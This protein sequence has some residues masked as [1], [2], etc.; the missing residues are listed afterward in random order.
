ML[1]IEFPAPATPTSVLAAGT[2]LSGGT[3]LPFLLFKHAPT[4]H[5]SWLITS[6]LNDAFL[7]IE[8]EYAIS[9]GLLSRVT[10]S[11]MG[12]IAAGGK[13]RVDSDGVLLKGVTEATMLSG[14]LFESGIA[15][16]TFIP[17]REGFWNSRVVLGG[18]AASPMLSLKADGEARIDGSLLQFLVAGVLPENAA[19]IRQPMYIVAKDR[20]T[21]AV[22]LAGRRM[23]G[24]VVKSSYAYDWTIEGLQSG[25]DTV[26]AAYESAK[27]YAGSQFGWI[28]I[29]M[30]EKA[31]STSAAAQAGFEQSKNFTAN[32]Y[33]STTQAISEIISETADAVQEGVGSG[34]RVITETTKSA[35]ESIQKGID[36]FA[37]PTIGGSPSAVERDESQAVCTMAAIRIS[38]CLRTGLCV[39][40]PE[41]QSQDTD[42]R[43]S[44]P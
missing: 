17:F 22:V 1:S 7:E 16:E 6:D 25:G 12:T 37:L 14:V 10:K 5:T 31:V 35:V 42:E 9:E 26:V 11:D 43:V 24:W 32:S 8:G 28:S 13:L 36:D 33:N 44:N 2:L 21:D 34:T 19:P 3:L 41:C 18:Y 40:P 4:V 29:F 38:F 39:V 30:S 27:A 20:T 15:L 23:Q